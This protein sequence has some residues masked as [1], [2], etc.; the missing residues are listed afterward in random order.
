VEKQGQVLKRPGGAL[1]VELA[2]GEGCSGFQLHFL[3]VFSVPGHNFAKNLSPA[4]Q[5]RLLNASK[6]KAA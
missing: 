1:E 2:E 5:T 4:S 6:Y 3:I